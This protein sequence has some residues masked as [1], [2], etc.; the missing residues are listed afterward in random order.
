MSAGGINCLYYIIGT[1]CCHI[2]CLR[3]VGIGAFLPARGMNQI[4]VFQFWI[5]K[6]YKADRMNIYSILNLFYYFI[7][8]FSLNLWHTKSYFMIAK[9]VWSCVGSRSVSKKT[10]ELSKKI[11]KVSQIWVAVLFK[12]YPR[13][14]LSRSLYFVEIW[15]IH[16][17]RLYSKLRLLTFQVSS[18]DFVESIVLTSFCKIRVH[19]HPCAILKDCL[20]R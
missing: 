5:Q 19:N 8:V 9:F 18:A 17:H 13:I 10:T 4:S 12:V 1:I 14:K 16:F 20:C 2:L 11:Y 6:K 3:N 7:V 15:Q